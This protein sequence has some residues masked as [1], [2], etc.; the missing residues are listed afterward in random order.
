MGILIGVDIGGT[1]TDLMLV[2]FARQI[3]LVD[4]LHTTPAQ[5]ARSI[6][7]R[8]SS[9]CSPSVLTGKKAA[10]QVH[11]PRAGSAGLLL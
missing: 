5:I 8:V 4:K 1:S 3:L 10:Q 11:P 7:K 6:T 9:C 2:D